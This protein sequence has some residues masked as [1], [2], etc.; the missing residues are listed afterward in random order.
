[1]RAEDLKY[2]AQ[3]YGDEDDCRCAIC[4]AWRQ[5]LLWPPVCKSCR[6]WFDAEVEAN[7]G[8]RELAEQ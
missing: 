1:M 5:Y 7:R 3:E 8:M 6:F 2:L 4:G